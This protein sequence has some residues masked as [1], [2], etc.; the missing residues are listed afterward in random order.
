MPSCKLQQAR[1][2]GFLRLLCLRILAKY[3]LH[4]NHSS[5]IKRYKFL[6][7]P[8]V[9]MQN[10][11]RTAQDQLR[12]M[13]HDQGTGCLFIGCTDQFRCPQQIF[14]ILTAGRLII[15]HQFSFH[16]KS[17]SQ[18]KPLLLTSGEGARVTI[19]HTI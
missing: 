8:C 13:C 16:A 15:E 1:N 2:T 18:R 4:I 10:M 3:L 6:Y 12:I 9:D 7:F 19:L 5:L 11:G 17:C 14:S